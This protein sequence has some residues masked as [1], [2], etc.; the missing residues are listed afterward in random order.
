[1]GLQHTHTHPFPRPH[2]VSDHDGTHRASNAR[3]RAQLRWGLRTFLC[4]TSSSRRAQPSGGGTAERMER[5]LDVA[6]EEEAPEEE[7]AQGREGV[8]FATCLLRTWLEVSLSLSLARALSLSLSLELPS[9]D[10]A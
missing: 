3:W 10:M 2:P 4:T 9:E 5:A 1:M 8:E 6:P 7:A